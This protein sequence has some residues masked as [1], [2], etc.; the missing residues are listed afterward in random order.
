MIMATEYNVHLTKEEW[1]KIMTIIGNSRDFPWIYTNPLL[2]RVG[3]QLNHQKIPAT[4][5][6]EEMPMNAEE[7]RV[8]Q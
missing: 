1:D 3:E 7:I 2:M 5:N 6:S 4:T 8:K